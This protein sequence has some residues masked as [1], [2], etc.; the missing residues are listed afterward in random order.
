MEKGTLKRLVS[1]YPSI[2]RPWLPDSTCIPS[3]PWGF[4]YEEH[5]DGPLE[6]SG[7]NEKGIPIWYC[8]T[9]KENVYGYNHR[10]INK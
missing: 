4:P 6:Q 1:K 9:C 2:N 8:E 5:C 3:L 10:R 7:I